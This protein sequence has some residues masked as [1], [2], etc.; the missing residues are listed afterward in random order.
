KQPEYAYLKQLQ[1]AKNV[2]WNQVQLA[3]DKWDYKQEG[4]TRA[5]A[6]IV[7]IIVTALTYG[8]GA[9]A[10]GGVAAS[11]SSTAAAA[12]TAATTTAA[13]TTVST[14]TAMQTAALVSLY[15]QAAVSII[16]NKGDVGKALK[17]L[18]T[19][20]TVKQIVTS[21]LTAGALNQMG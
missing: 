7:T 12:G 17:D 6:A 19:S 4:L 13:A 10:A 21:A 2:N 1:V 16:N 5:G 20:D 11:G 14:A 8:Y 3:Y 18:G 9:T 15:S